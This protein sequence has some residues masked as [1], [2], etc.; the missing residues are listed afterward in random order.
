MPSSWSGG[1]APVR[2]ERWSVRAGGGSRPIGCGTGPDRY[3]VSHGRFALR[4]GALRRS[5]GRRRAP[6]LRGVRGA[7]D[8]SGSATS[9]GWFSAYSSRA[10]RWSRR[11]ETPIRPTA[12]ARREVD[13]LRRLERA[14]GA[15]PVGRATDQIGRRRATRMAEWA[16]RWP[17]GSLQSGA[18]RASARAR[19]LWDSSRVTRS[20]PR[21]LGLREQ[22]GHA[23][24]V[25]ARS[26]R[27]PGRRPRMA[28]S[29]ED[30][31]GAA[32]E[33]GRASSDP[34]RVAWGPARMSRT[35]RGGPSWVGPTS[36]V[37]GCE[38][39][40]TVRGVPGIPRG[41][42]ALGWD[43]RS[44]HRLSARPVRSPSPVGTEPR[45]GGPSTARGPDPWPARPPIA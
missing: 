28:W 44:H 17:D 6:R 40:G 37:E 29:L 2:G 41:L 22:D 11:F 45:G 33:G 14:P 31:Q 20:G 34:A 42:A 35:P 10:H 12:E 19:F 5:E 18:V 39:F 15:F 13:R 43:R 21:C 9:R 3:A 24:G 1:S 4:A 38:S 27:A 16:R 32:H 7:P 30:P 23:D 26:A 36:S 8:S 25:S